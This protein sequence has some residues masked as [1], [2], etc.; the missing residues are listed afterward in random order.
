M[1]VKAVVRAC[2]VLLLLA[3]SLVEAENARLPYHELY[4]LQKAQMALSRAHTNL[5]LVLQI[6][7]TRPGVESS[8]ITAFI[9]AKSGKMPVPVG[10]NGAFSVPVNDDLLA[11]DPWILVNQPRGTMELDWHAGLAQNLAR[12]MTNAVHYGF[13]MRAVRECD[14]VQESMREF[15]PNSPRLTAVGLRL[16]FRAESFSPAAI[17]HG[18]GGDRRLAAN[19]L[20]ELVIPLDGDLIEEDPVMTLT[21]SPVVV[22]IVTKKYESGP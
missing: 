10:T 18:K 12:Q 19:L 17:I 7:S 21:E 5:S 14:D 3:P 2:S 22:E 8:E 9:D 11:E 13:L 4:Q 6:H 15:F 20:G 1:T 16:T